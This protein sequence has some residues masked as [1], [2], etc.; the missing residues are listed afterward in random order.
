MKSLIIKAFFSSL[1]L[2]TLFGCQTI[3]TRGQYVDDASITQLENKNLTKEQVI[4]LIGTPTI[5]PDYNPDTWYYIQRL[6]AR[7]AWL[8]PK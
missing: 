4:E 7:K 3:D 1:A 6:L 2:L 8:T 5:I